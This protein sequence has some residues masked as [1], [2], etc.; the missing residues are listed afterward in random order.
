MKISTEEIL[1]NIPDKRENKGTT[2]LQFKK[3]LINFFKEKNISTVVE[4]GTHHGYST[5]ILSYIFEEVLTLD[6]NVDSVDK[7]KALNQDRENITYYIED[8]YKY[9]WWDLS[10]DIGAVF[11]DTV[12]TYSCVLDDISNYLKIDNECFVIFD[13]YGLFEEVKKAVDESMD[14]GVFQFIQHIGE[15]SGSDCRP[16]KELKDW[17]GV[18]C[19]NVK[20]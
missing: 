11:I 16:G 18:I 13:D 5:R 8:A 2:T 10:E 15:P 4:L 1:N 19:K 3:D 12:H 20:G 14:A 17:E 6:I 7:A 9:K